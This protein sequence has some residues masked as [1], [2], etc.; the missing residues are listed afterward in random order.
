MQTENFIVQNVKCGGC[1][2]NIQQGLS[3]I[4]GVS[5]VNVSIETGEV[6]VEG[7]NLDRVQLG[8]KLSELG[9]PESS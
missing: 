5:Q 9:Y 1:A 3:D 2:S 8:S 6:T 7:D 4:S